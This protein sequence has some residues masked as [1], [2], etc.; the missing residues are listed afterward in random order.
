[1]SIPPLVLAD[2]FAALSINGQP[3]GP[4]QIKFNPIHV[5]HVDE[6][7]S[8]ALQPSTSPPT[9]VQQLTLK[10]LTESTYTINLHLTTSSLRKLQQGRRKFIRDIERVIDSIPHITELIVVVTLDRI[11]QNLVNTRENVTDL[12]WTTTNASL[13]YRH[14]LIKYTASMEGNQYVANNGDEVRALLE[15]LTFMT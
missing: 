9:S 14:S 15:D 4:V 10:Q 13:F 1:M 12:F 5:V 2:P 7:T 3:R 6:P 8:I 11:H